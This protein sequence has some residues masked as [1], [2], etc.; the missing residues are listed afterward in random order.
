MKTKWKTYGSNL[1]TFYKG[2]L[3]QFLKIYWD[4]KEEVR[5][6]NINTKNVFSSGF[7]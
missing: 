2:S 3:Q 1:E 7:L 5:E 4:Y 6:P